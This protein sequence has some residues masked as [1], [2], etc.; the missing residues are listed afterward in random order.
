MAILKIISAATTNSTSVKALRG[1]V[2]GYSFTNQHATNWAWLKL[3]NK[4]TAPTVGTDIPILTIGI[5]PEAAGHIDWKD[6]RG[7]GLDYFPLGI[8]LALT[9]DEDDADVAAVGAGSVVI[10]LFYN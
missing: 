8:G 2:D 5:P 10:D 3:Y 1:T 9:A 7:I 4:A 6:H